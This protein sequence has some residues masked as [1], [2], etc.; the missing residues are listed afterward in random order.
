[1]LSKWQNISDEN[2]SKNN[3]KFFNLS[4]NSGFILGLLVGY[5]WAFLLNEYITMTISWVLSLLLIPFSLLIEKDH[6]LISFKDIPTKIQL[7]EKDGA[8]APTLIRKTSQK[9]N[10]YMII[11]PI[12][13]SW[14]SLSVYA[15][16]KSIIR[17]NYAIFLKA[18][19]APSYYTYLIQLSLQ[20]GQLVG[21]TWSNAMNTYKRKYSV[22]ISTF[23]IIVISSG[24]LLF[25]DLPYITIFSASAGLFIGLIQGTSLKIMI[26][27][28]SENNTK[29]YS[30]INEVLKGIGFGFAPILAGIIAEVNI[31]MIFIVLMCVNICILIMLISIS[32]NVKKLP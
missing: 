3:F 22:F 19:S 27:Y 31:Y 9:R 4:W 32:K 8:M 5:F 12:L 23:M 2:K 10:N 28:G 17:F 14:L 13:F 29:K 30:T 6:N 16:S 26:D 15:T 25:Q 21:L 20:I 7:I 11:Y 24:I 1:M 18:F